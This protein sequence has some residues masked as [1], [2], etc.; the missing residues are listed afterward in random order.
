MSSIVEIDKIDVK[1]LRELIKDSRAK[2][3][4][5]ANSCGVSVTAIS[6]RVKRLKATGVITGAA[7]FINLS[8]LGYLC[9]ASI[10]I[11]LNPNQETQVINS[12]REQTKIILLTKSVGKHDLSIFLVAKSMREIDYLKQC[13]QKQTGLNKV[14]INLWST[15]YFN[16]ENIDLQPTRAETHGQN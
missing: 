13:I 2:L 7:Q 12:I 8:C 6:N 11:R 3:K 5:I 1:I 14:T 10:G 15:P 9:P 16:F 4:D